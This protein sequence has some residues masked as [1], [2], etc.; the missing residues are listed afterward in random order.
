MNILIID[1]LPIVSVS[2]AYIDFQEN[3]AFRE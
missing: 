2:L 1:G 3:V